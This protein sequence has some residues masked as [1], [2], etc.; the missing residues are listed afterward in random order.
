MK[1][2]AERFAEAQFDV[3]IVGGGMS[4]LCAALAAAA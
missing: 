3:L 1:R 2:Q 4:G